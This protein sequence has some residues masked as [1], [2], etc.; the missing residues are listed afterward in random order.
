MKTVMLGENG[1]QMSDTV[2]S[3]PPTMVV[4]RQPNELMSTLASGPAT[5]TPPDSDDDSQSQHRRGGSGS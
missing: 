3:R 1:E 4:A 5:A 2:D